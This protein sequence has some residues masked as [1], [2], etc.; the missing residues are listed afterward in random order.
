MST[1]RARR[2]HRLLPSLQARNGECID[3][4]RKSVST[5]MGAAGRRRYDARP[6]ISNRYHRVAL[7]SNELASG[8]SKRVGAEGCV[9]CIYLNVIGGAT[10]G[11][12]TVTIE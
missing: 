11:C 10:N 5:S 2:Y 3:S 6:C 1:P 8:V 4:I 9:I 12:N 7:H